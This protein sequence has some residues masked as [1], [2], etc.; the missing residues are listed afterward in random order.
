MAQSNPNFF[1]FD[2]EH[3]SRTVV[4]FNDD[5]I[6]NTRLRD[7]RMSNFVKNQHFLK[8]FL[9]F[10]IPNIKLGGTET[11]FRTISIILTKL[12]LSRNGLIIIF[13]DIFRQ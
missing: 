8:R 9:I 12:V 3:F 10:Q 6:Q 7:F 1:F 13:I 4:I 11:G 2:L 5:D